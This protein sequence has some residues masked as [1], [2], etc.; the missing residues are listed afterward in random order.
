MFPKDY[1]GTGPTSDMAEKQWIFHLWSAFGR[2]SRLNEYVLQIQ[3]QY[4]LRMVG[5]CTAVGGPDYIPFYKSKQL[6]GLSIGMPGQPN[7]KNCV[8]R[9]ATGGGTTL[10]TAAMDV[11]N[12]GHLLIILLVVLGNIDF[13]Y[14]SSRGGQNG[15]I[16]DRN[17]RRLGTSF[18]TAPSRFSS[19]TTGLQDSEHVFA[20]SIGYGV[21]E[22]Y[23][24]QFEPNL[25]DRLL[26]KQFIY[27]IP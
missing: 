13:Y 8:E 12:I 3:G 25:V 14:P 23:M 20:A 1:E 4:N 11:L 27:L 22:I 17:R 7:T 21:V 6:I 10:A 2:L 5:A 15:T 19:M 26:D 9:Q 18:N 16:I 24:P